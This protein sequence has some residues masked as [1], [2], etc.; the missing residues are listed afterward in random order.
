MSPQRFVAVGV[1]IVVVLAAA[2]C[3]GSS[4]SAGP[5]SVPT[6]A[7]PS[8]GGGGFATSKQLE[9]TLPE[10]VGGEV[11]NTGS[12][13]VLQLY[14]TGN[15]A[16]NVLTLFVTGLGVSPAQVGVAGAAD[17][18]GEIQI[19]AAQFN[20]VA[21]TAIQAQVEAVAK[22]VDANVA[23]ASATIGGKP[24]TTATY[25]GSHTGPV[26]AYVT[27]DTLYLVQSSDPALVEDALKQLP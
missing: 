3:G 12:I 4:A 15:S 13:D 10:N 18:D 27:G 25:P 20:G 14:T 16:A 9:A 1:A 19:I 11:L 21:S 7:L 26:V 5:P 2:G 22:G 8:G 23:L 17:S 24:V 6:V